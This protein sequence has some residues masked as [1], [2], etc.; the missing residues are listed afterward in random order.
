MY[1]T[2]TRIHGAVLFCVPISVYQLHIW[3]KVW[4]TSAATLAPGI[5][6][7]L[8]FV[9]HMWWWASEQCMFRGMFVLILSLPTNHVSSRSPSLRLLWTWLSYRSSRFYSCGWCPR[10]FL[11]S[12]CLQDCV[13]S[14]LWSR[15]VGWRTTIHWRRRVL[16]WHFNVVTSEH[17]RKSTWI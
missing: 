13:C 12:Q 1:G 3:R 10:K 8:Q 9:T 5:H 11:D 16:I 15:R 14:W 4:Q 7:R 2:G 17:C 6:H